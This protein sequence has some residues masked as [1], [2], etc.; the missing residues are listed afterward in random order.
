MSQSEVGSRGSRLVAV[1]W[2]TTQWGECVVSP[3]T[4]GLV[5][6]PFASSPPLAT[7]T[8][9]SDPPRPER[10]RTNTSER[11]LVSRRTRFLAA[12][13]KA[14][15]VTRRLSWLKAPPVLGPFALRLTT[16]AGC[17]PGQAWT[18]ENPQNSPEFH[19]VS[20]YRTAQKRA[21]TPKWVRF[22]LYVNTT[23]A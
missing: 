17:A 5:L 21:E 22:V 13:E 12:L 18:F 6:S 4:D 16:A 1:D 3:S 8:R 10:C 11:P 7:L 19:R 14:K 9:D 23:M 20:N 2:K 15:Y